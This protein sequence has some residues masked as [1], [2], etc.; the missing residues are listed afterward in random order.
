MR[1]NSIGRRSGN[2]PVN[3]LH[4]TETLPMCVGNCRVHPN[5]YEHARKYSLDSGDGLCSHKKKTPLKHA[6]IFLGNKVLQSKYV[7]V[8]Y[9]INFICIEKKASK[10]RYEY[11]YILI[12]TNAT[13]RSSSDLS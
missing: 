6:C 3:W 10:I 8:R 4:Y 12:E 13:L 1:I 5:G 11:L 9:V 2:T 7:M